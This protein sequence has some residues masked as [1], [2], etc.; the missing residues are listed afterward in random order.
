MAD[1]QMALGGK[2]KILRSL[3]GDQGPKVREKANSENNIHLSRSLTNI[4][5]SEVP[6]PRLIKRRRFS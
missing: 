3:A 6:V 2:Q 1:F 5:V 4:M